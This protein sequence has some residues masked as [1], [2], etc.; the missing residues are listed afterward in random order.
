MLG[1]F[2]ILYIMIRTRLNPAL[3]PLPQHER[4]VEFMDKIE[5]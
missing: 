3:A 5:R 2:Y 4:E 1:G